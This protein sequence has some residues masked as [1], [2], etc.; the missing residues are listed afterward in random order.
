VLGCP[1]QRSSVDFLREALG[2]VR[3]AGLGGATGVQPVVSDAHGDLNQAIG[4]ML[5]RCP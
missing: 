4:Q 1:W 5:V 3:T 2:H